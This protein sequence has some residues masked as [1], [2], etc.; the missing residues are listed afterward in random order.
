M[1]KKYLLFAS[2]FIWACN[3]QPVK[4]APTDS[5]LLAFV[6]YQYGSRV[7]SADDMEFKHNSIA[8][9][10]R[11][12]NVLL[13]LDSMPDGRYDCELILKNIS[14]DTIHFLDFRNTGG[15]LYMEWPR[16]R[17]VAPEANFTMKGEMDISPERRR[18]T[19]RTDL[20][21]DHN[22]NSNRR[23]RVFTYMDSKGY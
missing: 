18:F 14:A 11:S 3:S 19:K 2:L 10:N 12:L 7:L 23:I 16:P 22:N 13:Y 5:A 8:K 21:V 20:E 9:S 6:H 15:P 4:Q 17:S 1:T